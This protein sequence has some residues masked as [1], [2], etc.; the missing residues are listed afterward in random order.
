[1]RVQINSIEATVNSILREWHHLWPGGLRREEYSILNLMALY[2]QGSLG[3]SHEAKDRHRK[4]SGATLAAIGEKIAKR[5]RPA[6]QKCGGCAWSYTRLPSC[7]DRPIGAD[8][9]TAQSLIP[10][11]INRFSLYPIESG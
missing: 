1:M 7:P 6:W 5:M 4:L 8:T 2:R 9:K 3:Y 11:G 10:Q